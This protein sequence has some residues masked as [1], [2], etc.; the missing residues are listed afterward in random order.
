MKVALVHDDLMQW[1]GLER[2]LLGV[3]E[4]FPEAPIYTSLFDTTNAILAEK[5]RGKVIYPS[6]LQKLP[7]KRLFYKAFL[8]LYPLAFEQFN[9]VEY[10]LVI[11][12]TTRFAKGVIT[13]PGQTH[14]CYCYTPPRFLWHFPSPEQP[15][16]LEGFLGWLRIIDSVQARRVDRWVAGSQTIA[17]RINKIYRVQAAVLPG[18]VEEAFKLGRWDG[19]YFVVIARLNS[20]KRVD[21]LVE[22][23][24][25]LQDQGFKLK[26]IGSGVQLNELIKQAKSNIQ[27]LG[28]V[29][30]RLKLHVLS[31]AKALIVAGEEDFGLTPLEA[32][33]LGK[34]VI[35]FDQGGTRETIVAQKTGVFFEQQTVASLKKVLLEFD[36]LKIEPESCI[37]QAN[38]FSKQRFQRQFR[39][40]LKESVI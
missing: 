34:P 33:A 26:V 22:T 28:R 27:F 10:D 18:F 19:G 21:L 1:G 40:L 29:S 23:F 20:Y 14:L 11:S 2:I 39:N 13:K 12:L 7:F 8:P 36:Q 25:Q 6:F 3:C 30:E 24:N 15:R 17:K 4:L 35:A 37:K 9:L 5:F 38:R 31:G 32:Q 16:W